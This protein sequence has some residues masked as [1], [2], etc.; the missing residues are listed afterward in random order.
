MNRL[1]THLRKH[2]F[3]G[4]IAI[5]PVGL[6]ILAVYL[7]YTLVDRRVA[8]VIAEVIHHRIPGLGIL[9]VLLV[10]YFLGL[11]ASN[12]IG[13]E[14]LRVIEKGLDRIPLVRT[15][16]QVGKQISAALSLPQQ[17]VLTRVVLL[18]YLR[19]GMWTIGFVT[20]SLVQEGDA[21]E[22]ILKVFVPTPP[23]P[24]SGT[25]VLVRESDVRDPGWT[26]D[27]GMRTV[28]SAGIIGPAAIRPW[29]Q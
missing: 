21:G 9:L 3:R 25:I 16:Y 14:F 15:T 24:T 8:S 27:E 17:Q 7:L 5:I 26:V 6:S 10:L 19:P 23:N 18:E 2:V 28:L 1:F 22:R 20:G 11:L 12:L 4:V 29:T 13:R